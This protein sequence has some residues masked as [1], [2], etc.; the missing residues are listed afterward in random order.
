MLVES[1]DSGNPTSTVDNDGDTAASV[2]DSVGNELISG[3]TVV[4]VKELGKGL[5]NGLKITRILIG[6]YCD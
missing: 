6:D 4:L 1:T 5:K 3:D 2:L